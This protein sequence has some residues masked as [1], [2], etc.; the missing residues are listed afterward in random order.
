MRFNLA[1][2]V[3]LFSPAA[4]AQ[5]ARPRTAPP[6]AQ[7]IV[8]NWRRAVHVKPNR[9]SAAVIHATSDK[10]ALNGQITESL[11]ADGHYH[12]VL[13]RKFDRT[14]T[15]ANYGSAWLKDWNGWVRALDGEQLKRLR[16]RI[17][18]DRTLVFGP[19]DEL[20][21]AR[22]SEDPDHKFY[23]LE[24]TPEG[25]DPI[26]WFIDRRTW[27]PVKAA[28]PGE[29]EDLVTTYE[30]W[31]EF[32]GTKVPKTAHIVEPTKNDV[33]ETIASVDYQ[34][35][36]PDSAFE[37]P[38]AGP[39]DAFLSDQYAS[40][41]I[42][43]N[44]ENNHVMVE[45]SLNGRPPIW[46]IV[47]TGADV[48][49][50]NAARL[51]DYDLKPYGS[52]TTTGGGNTT[53]YTYAEGA[54]FKLPGVE[55][56]NQ[57][58][59][60]LDCTGL[61]RALGMKIGG[62]LGYDLLSRFVVEFDYTKHTMTLHDPAAWNYSGQGGAIV[63]ITL[64]LGIPYTNVKVSVPTE[65]YIPAYVVL[66]FGAAE[67]MNLTSP[68]VKKYRLL[69]LA[70]NNPTVNRLAGLEGQFFAQSMVRGRIETL[71][72]GG[73]EIHNIPINMSVGNKGAYAS[74]RFAGT[75][76]E[77][78][79]SRF[80]VFLDYAHNRIILE[81]T[82]DTSKPFPDRTTYG[83]TILAS[84]PDLHTY[85]ITAV[86]HGSPAEKDG[87]KK[88]DVIV[89]VNG[90]PASSLS[91]GDLRHQL[92]EKGR[93]MELTVSRAGQKAKIPFTVDLVSLEKE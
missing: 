72:L 18:E 68:F 39:R 26:T 65:P 21:S 92:G 30:G 2:L 78:I 74:P 13:D 66:D 36:L 57:H 44:F 40:P 17:F 54:N 29:D 75:V 28:R 87:F 67:T 76:G 55:L 15:V 24:I 90:Q 61:E 62:L 49:I 56:R 86:R 83:L 42:P 6:S 1:L 93:Q 41:P 73:L 14:E 60:V 27:L 8:R 47:D 82:P 23:T 69:Q 84:G 9:A 43:F 22:V 37:R 70:S 50:V 12:R 45:A 35:S 38:A 71:N 91:L 53:N 46:F 52:T 7:T 19:S 31:Q 77:T 89:D 4:L 85:T 59:G 79:Y 32:A 34:P 63:P 88:A 11:T 51:G 5:H 16:T 10:D 3:L 25:G 48:N 58:V 20:L 80:H 33:T 64:D 81:P